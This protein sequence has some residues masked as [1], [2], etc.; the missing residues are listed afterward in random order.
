MSKIPKISTTWFMDDPQASSPQIQVMKTQLVRSIPPR[1]NHIEEGQNP[2][3][4]TQQY[5]ALHI[6][7]VLYVSSFV[8]SYFKE[9]FL[10]VLK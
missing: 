3:T 1:S 7:S 4:A 5:L 2:T 9:L 10:A 6:E 8:F